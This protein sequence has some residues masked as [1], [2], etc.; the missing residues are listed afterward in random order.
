MYGWSMIVTMNIVAK[1]HSLW[2][3]R[4]DL[5]VCVMYYAQLT[6]TE[7]HIT[8]LLSYFMALVI[9]CLLLDGYLRL[10]FN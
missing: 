1:A 8:G 7:H 6:L 10:Q 2:C 3:A 4:L 9:T 5:Y